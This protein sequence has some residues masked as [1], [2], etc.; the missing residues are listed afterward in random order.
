MTLP[1]QATGRIDT[2][3]SSVAVRGGD[4][5]SEAAYAA[6]HTRQRFGR[7]VGT[8]LAVW[9]TGQRD[10]HGWPVFAVEWEAREG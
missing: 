6:W 9:R 4:D 8:I 5:R 3:I 7:E 1:R 2:T 10:E